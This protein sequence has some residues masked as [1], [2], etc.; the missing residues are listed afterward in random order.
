MKLH[1]VVALGLVA[2]VTGC[3]SQRVVRLDTGRGEPLVFTSRSGDTK[4]VELEEEEFQEALAASFQRVRLPSD[5]Q[6]AARQLFEVDARSGSFIFDP[7]TRR[8]TPLEGTALMPETDAELTLAYLRWC[9]RTGGP[10]DCLKL[11]VKNPTVDREGRFVLALAL[12]HGTVLDEM[13]EAFRDMADPHAMVAA[14][15]WTGTLYLVLWTV[16]EPVSKGLAA[17]MTATLVVYLGVDTFWGL[18]TGFRRLVDEADGALTFAELRA[19]GERYGKVMGRNAARAFALLAT[20]AIGNTAAGFAAKVPTLPGS[21][22]ASMRAGAE[23]GLVL[24][25]V[26][27][28]QAVAV[29]A[30]ALTMALAPGA[31]S[32]TV[33][34]LGSTAAAPVDAEGHNHHIATDKWWEALH[35]GGPWSP[36]FQ[37]IFDKAGMS[38]N[39]PANIVRVPGHKGP[40]PQE[41]HER[42]M[43]RLARATE[44]C[45]TM[46]QCREALTAELK[47]LARE[48]STPGTELHKLVTRGG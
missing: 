34:G 24:S 10:G 27:E 28:V 40:H 2:L 44:D 6:R 31:V 13:L 38:L 14:A 23:A 3:A 7:R 9:E 29:S 30:G 20:V 19:A 25:A 37:E 17:V 46:Q 35:S 33:P 36:R 15:M 47:R 41:Y 39:D 21:A 11:L 12:A 48:I 45:S 1:W 43:R 22:Q 26:G 18:I 5:P 16:P 32:P 8:V 42:I 4:P